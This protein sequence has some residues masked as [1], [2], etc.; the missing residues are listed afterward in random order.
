MKKTT[1]TFATPPAG[2]KLYARVRANFILNGSSLNRWCK[3]N[4]VAIQ[5]G[6]AVLLGHWDGPKAKALRARISRASES[7]VTT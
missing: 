1:D 7:R 3:A 4:G 2:E 6:R 5:N